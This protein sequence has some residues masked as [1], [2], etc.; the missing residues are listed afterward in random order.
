VAEI[1]IRLQRREWIFDP[2]RPLGPR[3][4]FGEVFEGW[5]TE[6]QPVAVKR[7]LL[8]A[9]G[10]AHR[11]LRISEVLADREDLQH[12]MHVL[13]AGQEAESDRYFIVM[14]RAT[15]SLLDEIRSD[16]VLGEAEGRAVMLQVVEGLSEVPE[17]V[18]R[19]LKPGNILLYKGTWRIADFGIAK[20]VE[21]STSIHT[22]R[23]A[24]SAPYAAPEQWELRQTTNATDVY[25]LACIGYHLL[26]GSPPFPGPSREEYKIQH[27]EATP[28]P[29]NTVSPPL[30]SLLG[31]MLR[32]NP[33]SR[34]SLPRVRTILS[35]PP[36]APGS[37]L[38]SLAEAS[39]QV[40]AEEAERE[41][42][43]QRAEESRVARKRLSE[44]GLVGLQNLFHYFF[45]RVKE[46]A[47]NARLTVTT[48]DIIALGR[49]E[50]V[51]QVTGA[52]IGLDDFPL[53]GWD[54]YASGM[55]GLTQH[56]GDY[57]GRSARLWYMKVGSDIRW[58][59]VS[60]MR[61]SIAGVANVD[62]SISPF[63][64]DLKDAD[65]AAGPGLTPY[66]L[67]NKPTPIDG[68]DFDSFCER[69]IDRLAKAALGLLQRPNQLPEQS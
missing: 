49:A 60:Y 10:A 27:L 67:A 14:P 17:L 46:V 29:L 59:E 62:D 24:L 51:L 68:E 11:E 57:R 25:A 69:W 47:P 64:V 34:P 22:L 21:E 30:R 16:S 2:E 53:S 32:K 37:A 41:A 6:G 31:M 23:D 3:G 45:D 50:L 40:S 52:P 19:D 42:T 55:L 66:Q 58:V 18:H 35:Q 7:L 38:G 8:T 43:R 12:V 44:E 61:T 54:V 20:F 15:K 4:G 65:I 36:P 39:A 56:T 33:E 1:R 48:A 9:E 63:A 26:S 28:S 5:D 13:D